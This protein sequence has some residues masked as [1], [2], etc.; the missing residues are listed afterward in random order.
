MGSRTGSSPHRDPS[1]RLAACLSFP[2]SSLGAVGRLPDP[3][4]NIPGTAADGRPCPFPR[5]AGMGAPRH[6]PSGRPPWVGVWR[7]PPPTRPWPR[8]TVQAR[9]GPASGAVPRRSRPGGGGTQWDQFNDWVVAG[10]APPPRWLWGHSRSTVLWEP[11]G[12]GCLSCPPPPPLLL[13][14]WGWGPCA[15]GQAGLL[16]GSCLSFPLPFPAVVL[17]DPRGWGHCVCPLL[18]PSTCTAWWVSCL[19]RSYSIWCVPRQDA[20]ARPP[21]GGAGRETPGSV[22]QLGGTRGWGATE[23]PGVATPSSH[24][25]GPAAS[26]PS[27]DVLQLPGPGAN[28][29][30]PS[31]GC[32]CPPSPGFSWAPRRG[33]GCRDRDLLALGLQEGCWCRIWPRGVLRALSSVRGNGICCNLCVVLGAAPLALGVGAGGARCTPPGLRWVSLGALGAAVPGGA[34]RAASREHPAKGK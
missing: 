34:L 4:R 11:A 18:P 20:P 2:G 15:G 33:C 16:G 1:P 3:F 30:G 22:S 9:A 12:G 27:P 25:S 31:W 24:A 26:P 21:G 28:P 32:R 8:G 7:G 14:H 6:P 23:G 17:R 19:C 13:W 5:R 10:G 29:A